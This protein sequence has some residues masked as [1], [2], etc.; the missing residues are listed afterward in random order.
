ME[1]NDLDVSLARDGKSRRDVSNEAVL[2]IEEIEFIR[3]V[4]YS[5]DFT[6]KL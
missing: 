2:L 6:S 3:F 1:L 4:L 5:D